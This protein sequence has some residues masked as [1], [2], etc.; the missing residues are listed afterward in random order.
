[1]RRTQLAYISQLLS[2]ARAVLLVSTLLS[3]ATAVVA[4]ERHKVDVETIQFKSELI[5]QVLPYN[6]LL[7]V[8]YTESNK[9]YP[10]LYL[11]HGLFGRY[12]DWVTRTNLA[13]YA[14]NY[15]VIIII[16]D[17]H[18]SWYTPT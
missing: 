1:M 7:P 10:V 12:D 15:D 3:T 11:L 8:G 2:L 16:P 5:G 18:N 14:A 6:A 13:E 4:Q 17:G 9:R